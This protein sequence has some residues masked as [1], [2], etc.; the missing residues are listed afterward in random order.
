MPRNVVPGHSLMRDYFNLLF[1]ISRDF[2]PFWAIL[3][4]TSAVDLARGRGTLGHKPL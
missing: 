1:I 4:D 2:R 3:L